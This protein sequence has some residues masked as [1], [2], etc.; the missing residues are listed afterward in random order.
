MAMCTTKLTN[1]RPARSLVMTH[2]GWT[3]LDRLEIGPSHWCSAF[4]SAENLPP[5]SAT[6]TSAKSV[7]RTKQAQ[8][9]SKS[10]L[11]RGATRTADAQLAAPTGSAEFVRRHERRTPSS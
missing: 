4:A 6:R 10:G 1:G 9:W 3:D 7:H 11:R 5:E 2:A 8:P